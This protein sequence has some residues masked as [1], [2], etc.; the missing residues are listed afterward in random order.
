[1]LYETALTVQSA[2]EYPEKQQGLLIEKG[3]MLLL[4]K[5]AIR[6]L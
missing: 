6:Q 2:R 5:Q 3:A 1:M 4:G